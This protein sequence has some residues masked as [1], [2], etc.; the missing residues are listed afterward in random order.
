M[1]SLKLRIQIGNFFDDLMISYL[2]IYDFLTFRE[3]SMF[4]N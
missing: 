1:Q 3:K 2:T 4:E